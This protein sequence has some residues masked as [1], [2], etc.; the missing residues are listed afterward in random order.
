MR[1][2]FERKLAAKWSSNVQIRNFH[3]FEAIFLKSVD[4]S[5]L[6]LLIAAGTLA[7]CG[8]GGSSSGGIGAFA[9]SSGGT[10]A[11]AGTGTG[12]LVAD[13][14]S[15]STGTI[16]T[17]QLLAPAPQPSGSYT[18]IATEGSNFT[19]PSGTVVYYGA[20]TSW[21]SQTFSGVGT[22]A[23]FVFGSDPAPGVVKSCQV[24]STAPAPAPAPAPAALPPSGV[25]VSPLE[26][27]VPLNLESQPGQSAAP[28]TPQ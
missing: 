19:V 16:K 14:G 22:C 17:T 6:L 2:G 23:N 10:N 15:T 1:K 5:S 4:K 21:V 13:S 18:T 8:G 11:I 7:G 25:Q 3:K 20:G 28:L 24:A 27:P 26:Q 12:T 9:G